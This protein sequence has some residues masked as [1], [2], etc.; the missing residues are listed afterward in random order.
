MQGS[1]RRQ[2]LIDALRQSRTPLS[3]TALSQRFG[4]SRQVIVQ[5]IA[6][7]RAAGH[8]IL[9][10]HRGYVLHAPQSVTRVFKV[11][12]SD[13]QIADELHTIVDLGGCVLDVYVRHRAYGQ[14]TA[15][16]SIRSRRNVSEL[17]HAIESGAS[18]PLKNVTSGYHYHTV[19]ADSEQT[20]DLIEQALREK[21][22]L[23]PLSTDE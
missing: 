7:L 17:L 15:P 11:L 10:T 2:Q 3:G 6:V 19:E 23:V 5:D 18:H 9:S 20:L 1:Q 14:L 12:H 4:V 13:A 21:G 8:E 22:Y 16:L